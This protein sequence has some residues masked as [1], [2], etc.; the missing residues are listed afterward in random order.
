MAASSGEANSIGL[1]ASEGEAEFCINLKL[2][3]ALF[4]DI[5]GVVNLKQARCPRSGLLRLFSVNLP[6]LL[7]S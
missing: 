4:Y 6:S 1:M 7:Y 2:L 3:V 5:P